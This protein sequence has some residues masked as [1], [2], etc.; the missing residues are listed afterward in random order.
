M[1]RINP[2]NFIGGEMQL[3]PELAREAIRTVA[4]PLGMSP[5]D[6][7][8]GIIK[9]ADTNMTEAARMVSVQRGFDPREF[10]LLAFGG[11]G[12]SSSRPPRRGAGVR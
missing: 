12:P 4:D 6:T 3:D 2:D 11:A 9:I 8:L 1:G 5:V 10:I 7:A